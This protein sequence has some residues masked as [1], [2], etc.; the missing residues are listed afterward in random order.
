MPRKG[1]CVRCQHSLFECKSKE[2][3]ELPCKHYCH[4]SCMVL[5]HDNEEEGE[6]AYCS[7]GCRI[8]RD[9]LKNTVDESKEQQRIDEGVDYQEFYSRFSLTAL[10]TIN[11]HFN[12]LQS[13]IGRHGINYNSKNFRNFVEYMGMLQKVLTLVQQLEYNGRKGEK[14]N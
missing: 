4:S 8:P 1:K 5:F 7:C 11:D 12:W 13:S 9:W 2:V 6:E 10:D 3:K 14:N